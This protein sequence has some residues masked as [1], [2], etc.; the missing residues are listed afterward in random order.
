MKAFWRG[1]TAIFEGMAQLGEGMAR[2]GGPGPGPE[3]YVLSDEEILEANSKAMAGDWE[4]VA[5]DFWVALGR[6]PQ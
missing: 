3:H 2:I 1:V 6:R 5:D 4:K